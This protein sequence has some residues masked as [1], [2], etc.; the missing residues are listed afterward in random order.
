MPVNQCVRSSSELPRLGGNTKGHF[1]VWRATKGIRL[2]VESH[3]YH[4]A[5]QVRMT[6]S[7][8]IDTTMASQHNR[9]ITQHLF[10]RLG[11]VLHNMFI[12]AGVT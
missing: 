1:Y 4:S 6:Y 10:R 8:C 3:T 11:R 5:S 7:I 2:G 9:K 12:Q